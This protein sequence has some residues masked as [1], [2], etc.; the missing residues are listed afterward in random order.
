MPAP[1]ADGDP[2]E[3]RLR[4]L[5]FGG[6]ALALLVMAGVFVVVGNLAR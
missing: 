2:R 1:N 5:V 3:R 6:V 4:W